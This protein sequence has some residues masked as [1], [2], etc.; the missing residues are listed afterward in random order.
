MREGGDELRELEM[1]EGAASSGLEELELIWQS[2]RGAM[3]GHRVRGRQAS[4]HGALA[5]AL[6]SKVSSKTC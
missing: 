1:S 5:W 2:A 3:G 4:R 6:G